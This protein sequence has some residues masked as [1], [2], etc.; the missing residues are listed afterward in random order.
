LEENPNK[1]EYVDDDEINLLDYLIVLVKRK[2]LIVYIT[3][4]AM[5]IAAIYSLIVP[6]VYKAETKIL[7]P[8][9][10]G[11]GS[12][13]QLLGQLGGRRRSHRSAFRCLKDLK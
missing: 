4:G 11:Q 6:S 2:K 8:Q 10:S 13:A 7:P 5:L 9:Q 12:A 3:L 1:T